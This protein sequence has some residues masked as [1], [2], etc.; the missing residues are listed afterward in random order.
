[1]PV[2]RLG[3]PSSVAVLSL[4]GSSGVP[5]TSAA[6]PGPGEARVAG[7]VEHQAADTSTPG[8]CSPSRRG[9]APSA[10]GGVVMVVVRRC[11]GRPSGMLTDDTHADTTRAFLLSLVSAMRQRRLLLGLTLGSFCGAGGQEEPRGRHH[12]R[13]RGRSGRGPW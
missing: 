9:L 2:Q 7:A 6:A 11:L 1:M 10:R 12:D 4:N 5:V 13:T 3:E 8:E